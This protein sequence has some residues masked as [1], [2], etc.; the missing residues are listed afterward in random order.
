MKRFSVLAAAALLASTASLAASAAVLSP[1]TRVSA[2]LDG[3]A[4]ALS[5]FDPT[6]QDYVA[7]QAAPVLDSDIEFM[8][9]D[10]N[11]GVDLDSSG[12]L[13]LWDNS[14][15]G[16]LGSRVIELSFADAGLRL[17][18]PTLG[19]PT[20]LLS[21]SLQFELLSPQS[22]RLTLTD[23]RIDAN[24]AYVDAQ[25]ALAP[26]PEPAPAALLALGLL[27]LALRRRLH[28]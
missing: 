27:G 17:A 6:L 26:V 28:R 14:G 3:D 22:V 9:A 15:T 20:P 16:E 2:T 21:G 7:G 12:L 10:A 19:M 18:L 13:R 23:A 25:L 5:G 4:Q 11:L 24:Y 1:G 8:S